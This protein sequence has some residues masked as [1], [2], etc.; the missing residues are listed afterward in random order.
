MKWLLERFGTAPTH[1]AFIHEGR[2]VTYGEVLASITAFGS[3][4]ASVGIGKGDA[5]VVVGDYSPEVFCLMLALAQNGSIV[6]PLTKNSVIEES[7]ALRVS[8]CDWYVEFDAD[9]KDATFSSRVIE[10]DNALLASFRAKDAS[11]LV[12]FS[13]GSTGKPKGIL[14]DFNLVVE[15]FR[16][17]RQSVV[18]IPF[19]MI[20]HF[21]GINTILAIT[22]SLGTVVTVSDRSL[23]K[24][25]DAIARYK[26]ELLPATPSFL[27][28]L[29]ASHLQCNYDLSSLKRIT[30]GTEVMPQSTLDRLTKAFPNV[31]LQQ[32]YGLSEVGVL[33]SQS[34]GDGSLW[35]RIGG[36]GFQTK[37]IDNVLWIKSE[38]AMVGYLNAPSEFD[39]EGWFNTQDQVEV[40]GD[41]FRI[42]GRVTDLINVG[43]QKVYPTEV[44]NVILEIENIQDVAVFGEKHALLGQ[45]V[46]AKVVLENPETVE[47]VKKRVR[48]V[49]LGKLASFKVPTKVIVTTGVLHSVR[50]KKIRRD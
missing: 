41:Y 44:E 38:Y 32:T 46:V 4:V 48:H 11:G 7:V 39:A 40:D 17:Q 27:T 10:T 9:G 22:A 43:G 50:Q 29:M 28:L 47:S 33:R 42:L 26:V 23:P 8:G 35:V 21:G 16:K 20:D 49:C 1:V 34:R 3:R 37:S 14:H 19:L 5:V 36:E 15:K 12:L 18:A 24:I 45:I 6:V 13:S 30:Y 31:V 25:C 2:H